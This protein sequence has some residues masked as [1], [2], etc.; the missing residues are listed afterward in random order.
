MRRAIAWVL[1]GL[2]IDA[3][4]R[5]AIDET[6]LDWDREATEAQT[7]SAATGAEVRGVLSIARVTSRSVLREAID[8]GWCRELGRRFRIAFLSLLVPVLILTVMGLADVGLDA[9]RL[10]VLLMLALGTWY[11][12]PVLLLIIG[13]RPLK[14]EFPAAGAALVAT[15]GAAVLAGWLVPTAG[16]WTNEVFHQR[17]PPT[18]WR[19]SWTLLVVVGF[20]C[21]TGV[22]MMFAAALAKRS[23][24]RSGWWIVGVPFFYMVA[25]GLC[26]FVVGIFFL[27]LRAR[28]W[29]PFADGLALFVLAAGLLV[30]TLRLRVR[31]EL[32]AV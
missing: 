8:F 4:S 14:A 3:R 19:E 22:A 17:P 27:N 29:L 12:P 1:A 30:A 18:P 15:L 2:P 6:L 10:G 16:E 11:L 5:R 26:R 9:L 23:G 21:L 31:T 25:G 28:D 20:S 24:L 32:D 13:W 7:L